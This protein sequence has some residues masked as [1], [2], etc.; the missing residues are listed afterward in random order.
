MSDRLAL[1]FIKMDVVAS[2]LSALF[3][4][5]SFREVKCNGPPR[6]FAVEQAT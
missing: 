3:V 1:L 2:G 6:L 4:A 5:N